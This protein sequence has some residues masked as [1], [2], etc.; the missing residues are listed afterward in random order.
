MRHPAVPAMQQLVPPGRISNRSTSHDELFSCMYFTKTSST[1]TIFHFMV[2]SRFAFRLSCVMSSKIA[3]RVRF[4]KL[5]AEHIYK[6][7]LETF[8]DV[9]SYM[10]YV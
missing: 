4:H 3:P 6:M 2:I 9:T 7:A 1:N 10:N 5:F 8:L